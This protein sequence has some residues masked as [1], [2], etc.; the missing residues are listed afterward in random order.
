M[1]GAFA[2]PGCLFASRVRRIGFGL[3]AV[4]AFAF[5]VPALAVQ[6]QV[7][8]VAPIGVQRGTEVEWTISGDRLDDATEVL[9]YQPGVTVSSVTP[10]SDKEV[11]VK[12][13]V[14]P[15]A[16]LGNHALRLRTATG[17]SNLRVFSVVNEPVTEEVEPNNDFEAPQA[18]G[19]GVCVHGVV[20][21]E[22][23]D[24][25]VVEAKQGQRIVA[26]IE[27]LRLGRTFF[28]PFVAILNT[29][30]FE[31]ASSDDTAL[32]RADGACVATAPAD[33]KYLVVVRESSFGGSGASDYLLHV[34]TFPRP[35]GVYPAG[36]R[37]GETIE[38]TWIGPELSGVKTQV[39]LPTDGSKEYAAVLQ[40][41]EGASPSPNMMRVI[42]IPNSLEVEPNDARETA[43][44]AQIPGA[45]NGIIDRPGDVD[46]FKFAAEKGK[47]YDIRVYARK[48][49]RTPLDSV[50]TVRRANGG[51]VGSNDDSGGPDS[52]F[53]FNAPE[54]EEYTLEI[55][56]HLGK[57][58]AHYVYRVEVTPVAPSLTMDLPEISRNTEPNIVMHQGNRMGLLVAARRENFGG[59][60][61]FDIPTL[62][63]GVRA[64]IFPIPASFD[65]APVIF[66]VEEG[67]ALAGGLA[68]I[69]GKWTD[70]TTAVEGKLLQRSILIR[71]QNDRDMW[72]Y[73]ADRFAYVVAEKVPYK[74]EV[75][76]PQVPIVRSGSME[77]VVKATRDPGF[78]GEISLEMLYDPPGVGSSKSIKIPKDQ[79]EARIPLTANG[80]AAIATWPIV[81]LGKAPYK[82]GTVAAATEKADL[83]VADSYFGFSFPKGTVEKGKSAQYVVGLEKK[84]E[85]SESVKIALVGLPSGVAAE[86]VEVPADAESVTFTVAANAEARAGVHK[87]LVCQATILRNGEPIVL[88]VGNGELRVDEPVVPKEPEAKPAAE[89]KPAEMPKPAEAA[90]AA[91]L[92]RLEQL[93]K[94]RE[95][96]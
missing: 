72:G 37:P 84:A 89:A 44:A 55:K 25:F 47:Q 5:A 19:L 45:F 88:T 54:S 32:L 46:Y 14:A 28:D 43:S 73:D 87:S 10:S 20:Q 85:F 58:D 29:E 59:D 18:I 64:E 83:N 13:V 36:G 56:D 90:P 24:Y 2:S 75:V 66:H 22:D 78:E 94:M 39:T 68:P 71:G 69:P 93:R 62:P 50:I 49:L 11:K 57:G 31:L 86:P 3:G 42:D 17:L 27:G 61:T 26:E 79:T 6:P 16:A 77:L 70:G 30:R 63:A 38:A 4:A 15:D 82:N 33:G 48:S 9:L 23:L 92:S 96:N 12:I 65:R 81:V 21:S 74:V 52:Y 67:A 95:G 7:S 51:G 34:G 41:P 40:T 35:S 53:R 76:Q 60:V 1:H 91:P 80:G 8:A